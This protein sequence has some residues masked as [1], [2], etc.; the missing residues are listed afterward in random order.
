MVMAYKEKAQ[1]SVPTPDPVFYSSTSTN[2]CP[3]GTCID[4]LTVQNNS[5]KN[6]TNYN[7]ATKLRTEKEQWILH[8]RPNQ[9]HHNIAHVASSEVEDRGGRW[10]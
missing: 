1:V 10:V 3:N 4:R 6:P 9:R 7:G 5:K 2:G 8:Q